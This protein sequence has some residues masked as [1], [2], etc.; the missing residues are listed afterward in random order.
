[1]RIGLKGDLGIGDDAL[2]VLAQ[3]GLGNRISAI[4][5]ALQLSEDLNKPLFVRW[6]TNKRHCEAHF[7][8]IFATD[9]RLSL[10]KIKHDFDEFPVKHKRRILR[11]IKRDKTRNTVAKA[12][13][14]GWFYLCAWYYG[15]NF[16]TRVRSD[17]Q[18]DLTAFANH[19]KI[20]V[21]SYANFYTKDL[22]NRIADYL[23]PN[24]ELQAR[25]DLITRQFAKVRT[26]G[27]HIRHPDYS[28]V[29]G[30]I[31][32]W[33]KA[34]A[35]EELKRDPDTQFYLS[36]NDYHTLEKLTAPF[37]ERIIT[38]AKNTSRQRDVEQVKNA[39][40][41]MFALA[42]TNGIICSSVSSFSCIAALL[43]RTEW[44][45]KPIV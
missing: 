20:L 5:A 27:V 9:G 14:R 35:N 17:Q 8:D 18:F 43:G 19:K 22:D 1:M 16:R 3:A 31:V 33:F 15:F 28:H 26:I 36:T 11:R 12:L 45:H 37:G 38:Q 25:L 41:D 7:E 42:Q 23:K 29:V 44:H 6:E 39:A 40:V 2:F 24:A 13:D 34:V 10:L 21:A 4:A 30:D 32:S